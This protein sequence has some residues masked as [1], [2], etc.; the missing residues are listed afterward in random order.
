VSCWFDHKPLALVRLPNTN[1]ESTNYELRSTKYEV[2]K[3]SLIRKSQFVIRN[4]NKESSCQTNK[5]IQIKGDIP[6]KLLSV[7]QEEYGEKMQLSFDSEFTNDRSGLMDDET[8][9]IFETDWYREIK[10]RITP[11]DNCCLDFTP[12]PKVLVKSRR[13]F[14]NLPS[15][16]WMDTSP[17]G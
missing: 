7:L 9:D 13:K 5:K 6:P 15:K 1:S 17:T 16:P 8:V 2:E 10:S 11:G 3:P 4:S 12:N 14:K